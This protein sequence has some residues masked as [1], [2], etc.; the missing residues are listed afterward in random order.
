MPGSEN[1]KYN[2]EQNSEQKYVDSCLPRTDILG[3]WEDNNY[4]ND[5][6][7]H[8]PTEIDWKAHIQCKLQW[9]QET[10]GVNSND[11]FPSSQHTQ[12]LPY[13]EYYYFYIL[14]NI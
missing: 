4:L 1:L 3:K 6:D 14:K 11:R 2:P 8:S 9:Q 12:I 7:Q 10:C 13:T 5:P